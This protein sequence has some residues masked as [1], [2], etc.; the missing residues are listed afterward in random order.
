MK[1]ILLILALLVSPV[2]AQRPALVSPVIRFS[3]SNG[4]P[5]AFGTLQSFQAGT[6]TPLSTFTDSTTG[7]VNTNPLVLDA[8]GSAS[9]FLGPNVY[10]LVLKNSAGVIQWTA[11]NIAQSGFASSFVTSFKTRTGAVVPVSGDYSCAQVTGAICSLPNLYNQTVEVSGAA[12]PQEPILNFIAGVSGSVNNPTITA[13]GTGYTGAPSVA[14]SGGACVT[15]PTGSTTVASGAVTALV[16]VTNGAGC[17]SAPTVV[18]SGGGGTGAAATVGLVPDGIVCVDN[19][20]ATRT[21][22][23][24]TFGG[25]GG[26]TIAPL[27]QNDVTSVRSFGVQYQNTTSG[28]MYVSGFGIITGGSGDSQT[29]CLDGPTSAVLTVWSMTDSFTVPGQP[30]GFSC[31]IPSM[32]YY[33]IDTINHISA[34]PGKWFE[35]TGFGG[36]G[37]GSGITQLTGDVL[38]GPSSGSV[39]SL[40]KGLSGVPFCTGYTPTNGQAVEY[41]IAS[42]PNPC[43][44]A[45]TPASSGVS[46]FNTRTGAIVPIA[47]DITGA[48]GTPVSTRVFADSIGAGTGA[49]DRS[50]G[51]AYLLRSQFGGKYTNYAVSGDQAMDQNKYI[52]GSVNPSGAETF[53]HELGT[54]DVLYYQSTANLETFFKRIIT[55]NFVWPT[56][57]TANKVFA[58]SCTPTTGT[59]TPDIYYLSG[60]AASTAT[61]GNVLTCS[62][63]VG[64]SGSIAVG[65]V[66]FNGGSGTFTIKVNGTLQTDAIGS[67]GTTFDAFGDGGAT[68]TTHNGATQGIIGQVFT[69]FT[70]STVA[71]VAF[72]T[73]SSGLVEPAFVATYPAASVNNPSLV[74]VSL[75]HQN[76]TGGAP[77]TPDDTLSGTYNGFEQTI[78]ASLTSL[79]SNIIFANTRAGMVSDTLCGNG[80]LSTMYSVCYADPIHPNAPTSGAGGHGSMDRIILAAAPGLVTNAPPNLFA[81]SSDNYG[82]KAVAPLTPAN[83]PSDNP[84]SLGNGTTAWGPG[85]SYL[86]TAGNCYFNTADN[87]HGM[88]MIGPNA[89]GNV[90]ASMGSYSPSSQYPSAPSTITCGFWLTGNGVSHMGTDCGGTGGIAANGSNYYLGGFGNV[91]A[92]GSG[93]GLRLVTQ[94][95][96]PTNTAVLGTNYPSIPGEY[97][98]ASIWNTGGGGSPGSFGLAW[99]NTPL[100]GTNA[101][102]Y[103]KLVADGGVAGISYAVD[104]SGAT[105][106]NLLGSASAL[107]F[108]VGTSGQFSV[109][110]SGVAATT[111]TMSASSYFSTLAAPGVGTSCSNVGNF[112]ASNGAMYLCNGSVWSSVQGAVSN[113][114]TSATP[115]TG[116]TSVTCA[117]ATCTT[118]RGTYTI[119]GG[120]ATTGT[121]ATLVWP[122]TPTAYVCTATMNGGT[123]FLGIGNSVATTTGMNITAGVTVLGLTLTV[124]YSC[125]P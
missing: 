124:N 71:T 37:S 88:A 22:C 3:D 57:T 82:Y 100:T 74:V 38:A 103:L 68:I 29:A 85:R 42:S 55:A 90:A 34:S 94:K 101:N 64:S 99:Q 73:T 111:S 119:V 17:T 59:W 33:Q 110:A 89:G 25:G 125:Q 95:G 13:G 78:A 114:I 98:Q 115:G 121:I 66:A 70:P 87:F 106:S 11:D 61:S 91:A 14:F 107:T 16:L 35:Y 49:T 120:T 69:G 67:L 63:T 53:V 1:R 80:S 76:G 31:F 4:K 116:V 47:S 75:N 83:M 54:N 10:K 8:T 72:T 24:M 117:T 32:Y 93:T 109:N 62:I 81:G 9:V 46:S 40:V 58:Q 92:S 97:L 26:G 28:P 44:T 123:G 77:G 19:P 118:L 60:L 2:L 20:G 96:A 50:Y 122:A 102:S 21:D 48:L 7:A 113:A 79:G 86:C 43:Y 27:V 12:A 5:L 39:S 56:I 18:F 51:Y 52:F 108:D 105:T 41:T 36:G 6:T 65:Y 112:L 15:Q 104:I 84:Y 23:T 30:A 45:A